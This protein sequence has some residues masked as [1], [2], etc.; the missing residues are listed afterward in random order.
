M[1]FPLPLVLARFDG[2]LERYSVLRPLS[3]LK[4]GFSP[5]GAL[6]VLARSAGVLVMNVTIE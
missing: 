3:S 2:F 5:G 4:V 1:A 6:L